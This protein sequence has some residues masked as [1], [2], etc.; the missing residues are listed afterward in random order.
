MRHLKDVTQ[1]LLHCTKC[2]TLAVRCKWTRF[3]RNRFAK[4]CWRV[5][6]ASFS[7]R[8]PQFMFGSANKPHKLRKRKPCH[9]H[10]VCMRWTLIRFPIHRS[11]FPFRRFHSD[12]KVSIVDPGSSYCR[13]CWNGSIQTILRHLARF[14]H[15]TH[16]VDPCRQRRFGFRFGR[17]N[18]YECFA[19]AQKEWWPCYWIHARQRRRWCWSLA[20]R[21]KR[22][23]CRGSS[24][25]RRI[26]WFQL[27]R[28]EISLWKQTWRRRI[29]HLLLAGMLATEA[30]WAVN[31]I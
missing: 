10:K 13:R 27:L 28:R 25:S 22:A 17:G 7:I 5:R 12:E 21:R 14:G 1:P 18:R 3:R 2:R 30:A 11:H 26:L 20:Y 16:T 29:R 6:I 19:R 23:S 4:R 24:H 31:R 15:V 9:G 8:A